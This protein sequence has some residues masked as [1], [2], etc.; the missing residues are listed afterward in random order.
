MGMYGALIG[1]K[2]GGKHVV[3]C[4]FEDQGIVEI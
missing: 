1:A 2:D 3:A 4:V